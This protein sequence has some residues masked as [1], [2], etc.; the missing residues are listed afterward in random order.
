[1]SVFVCATTEILMRAAAIKFVVLRERYVNSL[2]H[3]LFVVTLGLSPMDSFVS[4]NLDVHLE[5]LR[6]LT[7][8]T[9]LFRALGPPDY[10]LMTSLQPVY[11]GVVNGTI[12]MMADELDLQVTICLENADDKIFM[13]ST[14]LTRDLYASVTL[15]SC[16]FS[17]KE[18]SLY[19]VLNARL[20]NADREGLKPFIP[21]IWLVM[22]ALD[23]CP[24][25]EGRLVYRGMANIRINL[26]EYRTG[27]RLTW[28]QFSSCASS[29]EVQKSFIGAV[30]DRCLFTIELTTWRAR[31]ISALSLFPQESEVLLPPNTR[32]EVVATLD[33]GSGLAIVQLRELEPSDPILRFGGRASSASA[34]PA[35]SATPSAVPSAVPSAAPSAAPAASS[36][37]GPTSSTPPPPPTGE[38]LS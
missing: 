30:G 34:A 3:I 1:M 18:V 31:L 16:E 25:Y 38:P 22:H 29:I 17:S 8:L 35:P 7:P 24:P 2:T 28:F 9:G 11:E 6:A 10:D 19:S 13:G 4:R 20:R 14:S 27:R 23:L 33:G 21:Y 36:P 12:N 37:I 26:D 32:L 15:Y 5:P